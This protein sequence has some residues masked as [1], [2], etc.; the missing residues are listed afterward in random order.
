MQTTQITI[1][2]QLFTVP[3]PYVEGHTLSAVEASVLNQTFAENL[4]NNFAAQMKRALEETPPKDLTQTDLDAYAAN[5][6][7]GVRGGGPR[8][9]VDPVARE[10][11]KLA[12]ATIRA[13]IKRK[14]EKD[15]S[16]DPKSISDENFDELV[17]SLL[18][19]DSTIMEQAKI[20][21]AARSA[22]VKEVNL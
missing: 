3:Q 8:A 21:V 18:A 15:S 2:K 1:Q 16:F 22:A 14:K 13:A 4:R 9:F 19:Q 11:T 17:Q 7:F 12:E 6:K 5:Y 10:A 20:I